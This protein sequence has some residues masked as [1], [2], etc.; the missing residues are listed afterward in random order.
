MIKHKI[1][2]TLHVIMPH[3]REL[4]FAAFATL[5]SYVKTWE[6][7]MRMSFIQPTGQPLENTDFTLR[8]SLDIPKVDMEFFWRA[9]VRL[10]QAPQTEDV[11]NPAMLLDLSDEVIVPLAESTGKHVCQVC[12]MLFGVNDMAYPEVPKLRPRQAINQRAVWGILPGVAVNL[13]FGGGTIKMIDGSQL[14]D[15]QDDEYSG[16]VGHAGWETYLACMKGIPTIE[17]LPEG[18]GRTWLS[19]WANPLYRAIGH[20]GAVKDIQHYADQARH[21]LE[22]VCA[23]L[24][25]RERLKVF[26]A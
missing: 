11:K 18:R 21:N 26:P 20:E 23:Y 3:S 19:K 15:A 14:L 2:D 16:V 6:Q 5:Q 4:Q 13:P 10:A 9:G 17:I 25:E 24:A 22:M 8:Y 1:V 7:R 12:G